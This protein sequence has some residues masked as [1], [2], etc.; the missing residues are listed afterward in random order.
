MTRGSGGQEPVGDEEADGGAGEGERRPDQADRRR[1][2]LVLWLGVVPVLLSVLAWFGFASWDQVTERLI[3]GGGSSAPQAVVTTPA[4][5]PPVPA[6]KPTPTPEPEPTPEP[7]PTP[8]SG[9]S[10]SPETDPSPVPSPSPSPGPTRKPVPAVRWQGSL[11]LDDGHDNGLAVTGWSLDTVP[12]H[13]APMGDIGLACALVCEPGQ[14]VGKAF[15]PWTGAAPPGFDDC[16]DRLDSQ[17]GQRTAD[18]RPGSVVCFGTEDFRAG[19]LRVASVG[20]GRTKLDVTVW[21]RP[22]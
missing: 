7:T 3:G 20:G 22:G 12:P 18:V 11:L 15:V 4:P 16:A 10:P 17:L 5:A 2:Q 6:P 21:E 1:E 13:R 8:T 19:F 14:L 9:P